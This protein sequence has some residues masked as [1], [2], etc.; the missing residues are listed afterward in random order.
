VYDIERV[1]AN[2]AYY[3]SRGNCPRCGGANPV[4]PGFK[5]CRPC[6][7]RESEERKRRRKRYAEQGRCPSCGRPR[8]D[9]SY[10]TCS[11]C[12]ANSKA[13]HE[14]MKQQRQEK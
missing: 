2:A 1:R 8:D 12:R 11:I 14:A 6:A 5:R 3:L 10:K 7:I 9:D 13:Q 4:E